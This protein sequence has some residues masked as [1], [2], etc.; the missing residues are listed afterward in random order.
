MVPLH[1]RSRRREVP[2]QDTCGEKRGLPPVVVRVG[3]VESEPALWV[4]KHGRHDPPEGVIR[5]FDLR[6]REAGGGEVRV[7][8][9]SVLHV[10]SLSRP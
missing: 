4:L 7:Q 3:E 1:D 5:V 6:G 10:D 9:R 2:A 8:R